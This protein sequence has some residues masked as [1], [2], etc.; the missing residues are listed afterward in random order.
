MIGD[1][2]QDE[3]R[4]FRD[5]VRDFVKREVQPFAAGWAAAGCADRRV[6]REAGRLGLLAPDI[7]PDYGGGGVNDYR[8]HAI[9]NEEMARAGNLSPAF[10]IQG[11]VVV[12]YL[13]TL[14]SPEQKRRWLPG[15]CSG[16]LICA[17]AITEPGAGSDVSAIRTAAR[18]D[19]DGYRLTGH[20]TFVTHGSIADLLVVAARL[21]GGSTRA[22][23]PA[24][25][26]FA[27]S[28]TAPGV[29]RGRPLPKIG[30]GSMD[31]VDV[32]FDD[33][34]LTPAHLLGKEGLGFL[35]LSK[36]LPQERLSIAV[37]AIA[38]AETVFQD[39]IAYCRQRHTFGRAL[40]EHQ[41]LRFQLAEMATAL[42]VARS[43][44]DRCILAHTRREL[45]PEEA[46]MA[47]WWN[48]ELCKG[49]ADRC[50]QLHGA[51][52]YSAEY[53]VA[54]AFVDSRAQTIY[55]GTTEVMKE[56]IGQAVV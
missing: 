53:P 48:T 11:E 14:G 50:L 33:V 32:F 25:V 21:E 1:I 45:P 6:W 3:H 44:T 56:I 15:L 49:V 39:T 20:K 7:E 34:R 35:Y 36:N 38:M 55:G 16:E 28:P 31:T 29:T 41:Y 27:L 46:A 2:Y 19:G 52:G 54:H 51:Y 12:G 43:F 5:L 37:S 9:R 47:K 42:R 13:A 23:T 24:G 26:L 40:T 10:Y 4:A 22:G 18:R 17:V 8:F 30:L